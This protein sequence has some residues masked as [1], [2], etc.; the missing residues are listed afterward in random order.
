MD[1]QVVIIVASV[2]FVYAAWL[3]YKDLQEIKKY[4]RQQQQNQGRHHVEP[5][6]PSYVFPWWRHQ[7]SNMWRPS[8]V[9]YDQQLG[10]YRS[11]FWIY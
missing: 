11:P 10:W 3:S 8:S 1:P 5:R 6:I 4:V 9:Y 2:V 7:Y